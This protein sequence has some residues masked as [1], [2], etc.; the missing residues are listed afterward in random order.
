MESGT[1]VVTGT[2]PRGV[3][4]TLL[5]N[6]THHLNVAAHVR[7]VFNS[8]CLYGNYTL[9]TNTDKFG[10]PLTIVQEFSGTLT[11]RAYLPV[12][13]ASANPVT[14]SVLL[15]DGACCIAGIAGTTLDIDAVFS[16][17]SL[18][19]PIADRRVAPIGG[20]ASGCATHA[21]LAPYPWESFT[22]TKT[23]TYVVPVNWSSFRV[24]AQHRDAAGNVSPVACDDIKV[25]GMPPILS[26]P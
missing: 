16:A 11:P 20:A 9:Y 22:T 15:H 21:Q 7:P 26:P 8:G 24:N 19:A 25:E 4:M 3:T 5:A 12:I 10:A 2:N 18:L 6:T 13:L 14:G 17:T 1:F 23:F